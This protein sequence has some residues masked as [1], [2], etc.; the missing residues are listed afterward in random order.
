MLDLDRLFPASPAPKTV[1]NSAPLNDAT[2]ATNHSP[3][4]HAKA[5]TAPATGNTEKPAES[6]E[7]W[8]NAPDFSHPGGGE[9]GNSGNTGT[10]LVLGQPSPRKPLQHNELDELGTVGTVGTVDFQGGEGRETGG[11]PG[12]GAARESFALH[13]ASVMLALAYC[14]KLKSSDDERVSALL[15]L[16]TMQ[17]GEQVK[18]W[19]SLCVEAGVKPWEVLMIRAPA[20]GFDC[21]MCKHL[22]TRQITCYGERR[23]FDWACGLGYLILETGRGSERIWIAP[24]ECQSY[25]RWY[26]TNQR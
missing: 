3:N 21:T 20:S 11:A 18:Y 2:K 19:H 15:H 1:P 12:G 9:V 23:R 6:L 26:P 17:P 8:W 7:P 24:P 10:P 22:T 25:E 13:P 5:V 4:D 16:T 14:K